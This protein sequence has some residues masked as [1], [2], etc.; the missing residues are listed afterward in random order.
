MRFSFVTFRKNYYDASVANRHCKTDRAGYA[1]YAP[2][3]G[4]IVGGRNVFF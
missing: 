4:R 1:K 3:L 2:L